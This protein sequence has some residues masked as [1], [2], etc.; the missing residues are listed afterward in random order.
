MIY[1]CFHCIITLLTGDLNSPGGIEIKNKWDFLGPKRCK[2]EFVGFCGTTFVE[3]CVMGPQIIRGK[4]LT[5]H[6]SARS[7]STTTGFFSPRTVSGDAQNIHTREPRAQQAVQYWDTGSFLWA[8]WGN[9][10]IG[11][12]K[13]VLLRDQSPKVPSP[14]KSHNS[15]KTV[16]SGPTELQV[17]QGGFCGSCGIC[18]TF[19][20]FFFLVVKIHGG[21]MVLIDCGLLGTVGPLSTLYRALAAAVCVPLAL[22]RR[23]YSSA[24][25]PSIP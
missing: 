13:A 5:S 3:R 9:L 22:L 14:T 2:G 18:G 12:R 11:E 21:T 10:Y 19:W 6:S 24:N 1:D 20:D 25:A 23:C 15:N 4:C 8:L 16:P 7:T 17:L